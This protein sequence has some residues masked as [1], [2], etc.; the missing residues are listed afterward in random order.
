MRRF[1]VNSVRAACTTGSA[2]APQACRLHTPPKCI[3]GITLLATLL[4]VVSCGGRN[5]LIPLPQIGRLSGEAVIASDSG[6]RLM[7]RTDAWPGDVALP[8]IV[9]LEITIDNQSGRSLRIGYGRFAFVQDGNRLAAIAPTDT[10]AWLAAIP[11]P[12]RNEI[13]ER[14]LPSGPLDADDRITGFIYFPQLD[15]AD[16]VTLVVDFV[17]SSTGIPFGAMRIPFSAE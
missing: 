6:I 17:D 5:E 8:G 1:N 4:L 2:G 10:Q 11:S 16:E 12:T 14:A 13:R 7:V 9:P 3:A 15:E